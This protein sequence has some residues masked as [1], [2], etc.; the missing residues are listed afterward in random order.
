MLVGPADC[1]ELRFDVECMDD[2]TVLRQQ[3]EG[4]GGSKLMHKRSI[5]SL[6]VSTYVKCSKS[7]LADANLK[8][9]GTADTRSYHRLALNG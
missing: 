7:L 1:W 3:A 4:V 2:M 5:E 8:A 6:Y 9:T